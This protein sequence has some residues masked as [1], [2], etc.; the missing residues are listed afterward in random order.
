MKWYLGIADIHAGSS[1]GPIPPEYLAPEMRMS[2]KPAQWADSVVDV[3]NEGRRAARDFWGE[4]DTLAARLPKIDAAFVLSDNIEGRQAKSGGEGLIHN[5]SQ[6]QVK[7][8]VRIL[9]HIL[10]GAGYPPVYGVRGTGYHVTENGGRECDDEVYDQTKNMQA[11]DDVLFVEAGGLVWRLDHNIGRSGTPYGKS[12]PLSKV[13]IFNTLK[14]S[15]D[16]EH[17]A[18]VCLH[19]HVHYCVSS[20]FPMSNKI[21]YTLPALKMRGE[22]YGRKFNDFYDVGML[23]FRQENDGEPV[24]PVPLRIE[25]GHSLPPLHKLG[26]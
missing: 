8:A 15:I 23:L 13:Q 11:Y 3:F 21:G 19:G 4:L 2:D 9:D 22:S 7:I 26:E 24:V 6:S 14:S 17:E 16:E 25:T 10:K 1:H 5:N 18:N 20:G 12:T